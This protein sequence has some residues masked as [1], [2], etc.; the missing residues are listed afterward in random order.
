MPL[1]L[2]LP[3][4]TLAVYRLARMVTSASEEGPFGVLATV[5]QWATLHQ[6][7]WVAR[8]WLCFLCVTFWL[9]LAVSLL[10]PL[11][12]PDRVIAWW[13]MAGANVLLWKWLRATGLEGADD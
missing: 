8:G 5:R 2:L 3:L 1:W 13:G 9:S 7:S 4:A 10:L 6:Q 11:S 12:W